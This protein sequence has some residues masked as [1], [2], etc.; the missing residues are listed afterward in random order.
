MA[1]KERL[2]QYLKDCIEGL[3]LKTGCPL[4]ILFC[5]ASVSGRSFSEAIVEFNVH[6]EWPLASFELNDSNTLLSNIKGETDRTEEI[7]RLEDFISDSKF[8]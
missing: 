1:K 6:K 4:E 7:S 5:D 8:S 3:S 2:C